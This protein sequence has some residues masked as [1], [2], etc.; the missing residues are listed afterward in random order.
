MAPSNALWIHLCPYAH[1]VVYPDYAL[2]GLIHLRNTGGAVLTS[3]QFMV[4]AISTSSFV[5]YF[6]LS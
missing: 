6:W 3:I 1:A 5:K 2:W 4:Y